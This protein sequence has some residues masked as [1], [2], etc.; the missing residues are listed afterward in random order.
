M[1]NAKRGKSERYH[2]FVKGPSGTAVW[3]SMSPAL[4]ISACALL[5][6]GLHARRGQVVRKRN[7]HPS[8]CAV[9]SIVLL[10]DAFELWLN[11]VVDHLYTFDAQRTLSKRFKAE[12]ANLSTLSKYRRIP[13]V[14]ANTPIRE[15]ADLETVVELRNEIT[16]HLARW[17]GVADPLPPWFEDLFQRD[18]FFWS[19]GENKAIGIP[20]DDQVSSYALAYWAWETIDKAVADFLKALGAKASGVE[21]TARNFQRY[22]CLCPPSRLREYDAQHNLELTK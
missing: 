8:F 9:G 1:G 13:E 20:M 22:R 18:L 7:T 5:E 14:A 21:L 19:P 17:S 6:R 2:Q 12:M 11:E 15:N 4:A 16:H 10:V 3:G